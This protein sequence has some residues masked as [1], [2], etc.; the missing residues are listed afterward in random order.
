MLRYKD[1]EPILL[2]L[3]SHAM[4]YPGFLSAENLVSDEDFSIVLM[5]ST[6]EKIENWKTWVE[7]RRTQ[8]L[9]RQAKEVVIESARITTYRIMPT[10][11][12]R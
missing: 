10:V 8:D 12:W 2:Q 5:I 11:D 1:L 6:W 3:R 4:Q 9:I 7:S